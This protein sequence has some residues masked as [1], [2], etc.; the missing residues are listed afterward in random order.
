MVSR[1]L[2]RRVIAGGRLALLLLM[3]AA[4]LGWPAA[5]AREQGP[6]MSLLEMR[7]KGVVIQ[8]WDLSC[9]AAALATLLEFQYGESVPEHEIAVS[10]MKREEYLKNPELVR[11]REGFSLLDL[12]RYVESRGYQGV[13]LGRLEL[14]DL[15]KRAPIMVAVNLHGYNHFVIFRGML[16][17]RVLIADPSWGNRTLLKKVFL[18]AWIDY[19]TLGRTGFMVRSAKVEAVNEKSTYEAEDFVFLR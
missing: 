5:F 12:K 6:V 1:I 15:V 19:P 17:N 14:D 3:A 4:A 11:A 16:G 10:L 7:Q 8:Q 2:P 18:N 9:G 13:G